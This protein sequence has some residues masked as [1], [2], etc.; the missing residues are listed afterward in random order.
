M[1][2][3]HAFRKVNKLKQEDLAKYL[4]TTRAFISMIETGVSKLP[5]EKLSLLLNNTQG[6]DTKMLVDNGGIY[7]GNNNAGDVNVQI[8]QNRVNDR[9]KDSDEATQIAVLEK[10]NQMLR[11]QI[12]FMK[13]L[14]K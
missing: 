14:I 13:T 10:E 5:S 4:N 7:A 8:G 1:V 11:E 6:W 9:K 2:D 12:E 3:L